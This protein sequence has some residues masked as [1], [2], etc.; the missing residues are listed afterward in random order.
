MTATFLSSAARL[1]WAAALLLAAGGCLVND[2]EF[3]QAQSRQES[4][5]AELSRLLKENDQMNR[6]LS[7]LYADR[8]ILSAHV[9]M[10]AA[11]ALHNRVTERFRP[12][13]PAPAAPAPARAAAP[14]PAAP[15]PAS[16]SPAPAPAEAGFQS[17]PSGAV[18]WGQ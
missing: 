18:D 4:L 1:A 8:E 11:V 10:T 17:R 9:A 14:R 13:P 12:A 2:G 3:D 15:R 6:E 7:R 16:S 5:E